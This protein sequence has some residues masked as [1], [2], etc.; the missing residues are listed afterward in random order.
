MYDILV[1]K[2]MTWSS[3]GLQ[4]DEK[5]SLSLLMSLIVLIEKIIWQD[6]RGILNF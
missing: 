5:M 1:Y 6:L 2:L 4:F 3:T